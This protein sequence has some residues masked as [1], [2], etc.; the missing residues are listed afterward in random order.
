MLVLVRSDGAAEVV[1]A[2]TA[3]ALEQAITRQLETHAIAP[4][5]AKVTAQL[6]RVREAAV[7]AASR[8]EPSGAVSRLAPGDH[9][10]MDRREWLTVAEA[11]AHLGVSRRTVERRVASGEL[12]S[13]TFG[14]ARRVHRAEL[15]ADAA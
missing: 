11:A 3:E 7:S 5:L 10:R 6:G 1:D 13:R 9:D 12:R 2:A 4:D 15:A 14:R 8:Q